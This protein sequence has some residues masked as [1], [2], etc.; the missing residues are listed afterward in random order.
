[1]SVWLQAALNSAESKKK[2]GIVFETG[3]GKL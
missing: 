2:A 3:L 1:M